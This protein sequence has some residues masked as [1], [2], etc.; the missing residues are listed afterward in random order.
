MIS[1][2]LFRHLTLG[3]VVVTQQSAQLQGVPVSDV[4][5]RITLPFQPSKRKAPSFDWLMMGTVLSQ[6]QA[7]ADQAGQLIG[8]GRPEAEAAG[9]Q[10]LGHQHEAPMTVK[11]SVTGSDFWSFTYRPFAATHILT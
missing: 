8:P 10:Q 9:H 3:P 1:A 7:V 4:R 6:A 2:V 5:G 11:P